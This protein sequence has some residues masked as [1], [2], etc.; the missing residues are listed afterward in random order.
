MSLPDAADRQDAGE[1][2]FAIGEVFFSRTDPRGVIR[3]GNSVFR[4]VAAFDWPEMIGAPHRIIRHPDMPRGVF[5]ILWDRIQAGRITC[6]YVKN[7]SKDGLHYWV[8]AVI[9]PVE[10]GYLSVR[11]KPTSDLFVRVRSLYADLL[12]REAAEGLSPE[13]GA[14]ALLASL[15]GL[16]FEDYDAFMAAAMAAEIVA[17]NTALG[18]KPSVWSGRLARL[19]DQTGDLARQC[20]GLTRQFEAIR[21]VPINLGIAAVGLGDEGRPIAVIAENYAMM[22]REV[23]DKLSTLET[24]GTGGYSA[25]ARA[26]VQA[27]VLNGAADLQQEAAEDFAGATE[28]S[29]VD[30]FQEIERLTRQADAMRVRAADS[31]RGVCTELS[32]LGLTFRDLER[33]VAGLDVTRILCRVEGGRLPPARAS[34]L[35]GIIASLDGFHSGLSQ[36][37][38]ALDQLTEAMAETGTALGAKDRRAVRRKAA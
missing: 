3:S 19:R 20:A 24:D 25:I 5:R 27:M 22:C 18:R 30:R 11:I 7:R 14:E 28:A 13:A 23:F 16:G 4:R 9:S 17:R 2:P 34:A 21:A 37:L 32:V 31:L 1:A 35:I 15:A 33:L 36:R 12:A 26:A 29:P 8:F 38:D 6:A 10:D